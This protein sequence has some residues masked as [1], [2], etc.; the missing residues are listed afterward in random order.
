MGLAG[1]GWDG[2]VGSF[3][4]VSCGVFLSENAFKTPSNTTKQEHG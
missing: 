2:M 4:G 3:V 1:V